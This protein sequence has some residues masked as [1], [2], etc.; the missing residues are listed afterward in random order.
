[1]VLQYLQIPFEY[2]RLARLLQTETHGTVFS[3]LRFLESLGAYV[4]VEED[5][6]ETL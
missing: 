1:M 6:I 3:H 4:L 2:Q 5:R